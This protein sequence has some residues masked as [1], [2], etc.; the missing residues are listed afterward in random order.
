[1]MRM[2]FEAYLLKFICVT[3][4]PSACRRVVEKAIDGNEDTVC[5]YCT[6]GSTEL[7]YEHLDD[8]EKTGGYFQIGNTIR[9]WY[10]LVQLDLNAEQAVTGAS[11]QLSLACVS[12]A[13]CIEVEHAF[14]KNELSLTG[15]YFTFRVNSQTDCGLELNSAELNTISSLQ[16]K[17]DGH[18]QLY[19]TKKLIEGDC[20]EYQHV[21]DVSCE[22]P[23][24]SSQLG[25]LAQLQRTPKP[26][27]YMG[28]EL[29]WLQTDREA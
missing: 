13:S 6:R 10:T 3:I 4:R 29:K 23:G 18:L 19:W 11:H 5:C 12:L 25:P 27:S 7:R 15:L 1:M 17:I 28:L 21:P 22:C 26:P 9:Y 8:H 2:D 16:W 24:L 20:G 14:K